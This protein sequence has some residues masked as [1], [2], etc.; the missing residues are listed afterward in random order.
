MIESDRT[1]ELQVL[2]QPSFSLKA[3]W[4]NISVEYCCLDEVGEFD[5]AMPSQAISVAFLPHERVTWSVDGNQ[6][7]STPLPPGSVF[8]YGDRNFVWHKRERES[9]YVN[10][11]LDQKFLAQVA[12]ESSLSAPVELQHRVIF[13]DSTIL[14]I[15]QMF[16]LEL[17]N[18]SVAGKLYVESLRNLL[19]VHLLRNYNFTVAKPVLVNGALDAFKLNKVKDLIEDQLHEDLSIADM[20]AVV[21]MSQFHFARAFKTA[22]GTSPHRYLILRRMERAKILLKVT[23]MSIAQIAY[24]LGF[25]NQSH[26]IAQFRKAFGTTP[27]NYRDSF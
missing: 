24:G 5:F 14:Y 16:K 1:M 2:Q 13:L 12:L 3:C 8:I 7:Q 27:K 20:A 11:L 22:T 23:K 21:H 10:I 15:A 19:A 4:D 17:L 6:S 26:F 25:A 9:E 18:G